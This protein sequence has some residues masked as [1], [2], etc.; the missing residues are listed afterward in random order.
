VSWSGATTYD[1]TS[2]DGIYLQVSGP[3]VYIELADQQGSAG[4]DVDGVST[5]GWGHVHTIYRDPAD[6]YAGS[7][8][9]QEGSGM[10]GG[11]GGT[12]PG[13]TPPA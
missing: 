12:P 8:T 4:A 7:V 13:G 6:D 5:S 9:Q 2:G 10:S 1:V 11:P 3:D